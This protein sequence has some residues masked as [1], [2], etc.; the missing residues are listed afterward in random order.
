MIWVTRP[1]QQQQQSPS[2]TLAPVPL[3]VPALPSRTPPR[4]RAEPPPPP[5][6]HPPPSRLPP[7]LRPPRWPCWLVACSWP[8]RN[9]KK[10]LAHKFENNSGITFPQCQISHATQATTHIRYYKSWA[11]M[12]LSPVELDMEPH[13]KL[14]ALAV[15]RKHRYQLHHR[16]LA[17]KD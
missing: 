4:P 15:Q 2:T 10:Q 5:R 3:E 6:R 8:R 13:K 7:S 11:T 12:G 17:W 14:L 16:P 9:K 1:S